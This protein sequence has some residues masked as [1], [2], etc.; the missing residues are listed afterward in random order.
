MTECAI[1]EVNGA[2]LVPTLEGALWCQDEAT[3]I[4]ADMHFEKGSAFA[5]RGALLPPYDTRATLRRL[6]AVIERVKPAR[7]ISLG[8]AFHDR[9][10]EARMEEADA[11]ALEALVAGAEWTWVLGNHDPAPP[12]RFKGD[13]VAAKRVGTLVFRHEPTKGRADGEIAGHLHPCARVRTETRIQRRRC[14]ATDGRRLIMPAFGAYAG[15]LNVLDVAFSG[16][17]TA[18]T[19]WVL[20]RARVYPISPRLLVEDPQDAARAAG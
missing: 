4:I 8:D 20:G 19:A 14:F 1:L 18:P 15:G 9:D 2:R 12:K 17:F 5:A 3:L 7:V 6:A 13:V 10:A 16:I 11:A